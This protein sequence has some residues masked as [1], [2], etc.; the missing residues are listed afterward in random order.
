MSPRRSSLSWGREMTHARG[1]GR[2]FV[3]DK[4]HASRV[5]LRPTTSRDG[6]RGDSEYGVPGSFDW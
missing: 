6:S 5:I 2:S 3:V 4:E 1:C